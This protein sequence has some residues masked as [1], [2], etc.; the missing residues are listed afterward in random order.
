MCDGEHHRRAGGRQTVSAAR[1]GQDYRGV[2]PFA[3]GA[4][5]DLWRPH[6]RH[7]QPARNRG[8]R[9]QSQGGSGRTL[10][11]GEHRHP[12]DCCR[13]RLCV[14]E[15]RHDLRF[16]LSGPR[17][18][19]RRDHLARLGWPVL[20]DR[21][22]GH[23]EQCVRLCRREGSRVQGGT[24]VL[25]GPG[26]KGDVPKDMKR[27]DA[28]TRWVEIQPRVHV[29][30]EAD[31]PGA[32][33]VLK[34]IKVQGLAQHYG[35]PAP[36]P[37][38]YSYEVPKLA[39]KVASSLMKFEDPLQFWSIFSAAMNENPPPESQIKAVLPQFKYLGIELGKQWKREDVNPLILEEMKLAAAE[40]G[41]MMSMTA[42][43][44]TTASNGWF[45][46]PVTLGA[47]GAGYP[48][49]GQP[50]RLARP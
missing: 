44:V 11:P 48:L 20:H 39:P 29:K 38:K 3:G 22:R 45:M 28:P 24:Y 40:I 30:N 7:V 23:V 47:P 36:Q 4:G 46:T 18:G 16:W 32:L 41:G 35:K 25:V 26:W 43:I 13:V 33:K 8:R 34:A 27:I 9:T 12:D 50:A 10:A 1:A 42:P 31:L 37:M 5:G 6:R 2:E 49:P 14:A 19:A 17:P 15:R 21:D